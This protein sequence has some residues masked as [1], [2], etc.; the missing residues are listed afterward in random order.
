MVLREFTNKVISIK[1]LILKSFLSS[2]FQREVLFPSLAKR[3]KGRF[4]N[5]V[6]LLLHFLVKEFF[7]LPDEQEK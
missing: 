7:M 3:G 6:A 4:S 2:L 5:N 1:T